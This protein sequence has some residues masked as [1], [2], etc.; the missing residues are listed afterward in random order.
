MPFQRDLLFSIDCIGVVKMKIQHLIYLLF[1]S[2]SLLIADIGFA[3]KVSH[4]KNRKWDNQKNQWQFLEPISKA[5]LKKIHFY[6]SVH[7][8]KKNKIEKIIYPYPPYSAHKNKTIGESIEY[9]SPDEQVTHREDRINK[10]LFGK[11]QYKYNSNKQMIEE[12]YFQN[13]KLQFK[14]VN[15]YSGK[16]LIKRACYD[17]ESKQPVGT[18]LYYSNKGNLLKEERYQMTDQQKSVLML[19]TKYE[20]KNNQLK[21]E[22]SYSEGKPFGFWLLYDDQGRLVKKEQY[23]EELIRHY[24][25]YY[26]KGK[27][28]NKIELYEDNQLVETVHYNDKGKIIKREGPPDNKKK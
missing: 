6:Y 1:L 22:K 13:K 11:Y 27:S 3:Q 19:T 16:V 9:Y 21:S 7:Y 5:Y 17:G 4:Y 26:S 28:I 18:W 15:T 10:K 12:S 23:R 25:Y 24:K 14:Y 8:N 2:V 20:Y